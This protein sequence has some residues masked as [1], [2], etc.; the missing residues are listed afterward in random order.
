ML[1]LPQQPMKLRMYVSLLKVDSLHSV[2]FKKLQ[3]LKKYKY[4]E[5]IV[6][7]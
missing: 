4:I 3:K 6:I 7:I 1:R 2:Y 5:K